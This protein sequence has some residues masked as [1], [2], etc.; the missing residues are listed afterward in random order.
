MI[1]YLPALTDIVL[2]EIPDRVTLAVEI[3][4]C[5]GSCP[6]CHSPFLREDIGEELT[7]A[8]LDA[9]LDDN[10]GV[11]CLLFLGEGN[12]PD[13]LLRLAAHIR[14]GHPA[15]EL[16][17]YSGRCGVEK[18]IREM[19]DYVKIGPYIAELGPLNER[20]TNQR[21]YCRGED[22]TSRFWRKE[23]TETDKT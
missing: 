18:E 11:N 22:I 3:T 12:D 16:A 6:G 2:E 8:A 14:S 4:N 19:F 20:T 23:D 9:L 5:Q 10:F 15:V 21:L 17:L 7:E 1:K 13:S